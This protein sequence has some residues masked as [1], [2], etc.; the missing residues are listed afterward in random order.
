MRTSTI[1]LGVSIAVAMLQSAPALAD[2][3]YAK[4]GM[5]AAQIIAASGGEARALQKEDD[6]GCTF[7]GQEV[8][9]VAPNKAIAGATFDVSFCTTNSNGRLTSVSLHSTGT[10]IKGAQLKDA[11]ISQYGRPVSD[12]RGIAIWNDKK[13]ANTITFIDMGFGN[14]TRIEYKQLGNTGL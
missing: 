14:L 1:G 8:I 5:T 7:K 2:W 12:D 4:W 6:I 9:A 13:S 3:H 10:G 11:L